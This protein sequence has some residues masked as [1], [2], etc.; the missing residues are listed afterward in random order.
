MSIT[1]T[2]NSHK[3][4][5]PTD[6]ETLQQMVLQ[7]LEDNTD[8][9]RQLA[10]F[11]R[12]IFG[13]KSE[14]F[15]PSQLQ[16]FEGILEQQDQSLPEQP[17]VQVETKK[18]KSN[19]RNGRRPLPADLPRETIEHHPGKEELTCS[20]CG[21]QKT[22]IGEEVTE[23]LDYIPASFVVRKHVRIKYACKTCQGQI[24]IADLPAFPIEKGRP[25][26]G[27]LAHVLTNKYCDHLPLNRQEDIFARHGIDIK[28]STMCDWVRESS[29]LLESIVNHL[30]KQILSSNKIHTD[31]TK[32]PV[33]IRGRPKTK[34][35]YLWVY[36][37]DNGNAVY[38]Y[39]PDRSRDGPVRF[40]KDFKGYL[41]ADAYSGY[42][43]VFERGDVTEVGCWAHARRK[44]FDS[45]ETDPQRA[46]HMLALIKRLYDIEK[47]ARDN[48]LD[49]SAIRALRQSESTVILKEIDNKLKQWSDQVLP[50]SPIGKAIGYARGQWEA[51]NRYVD[52]GILDIDNNAAE[53]ALKR[54]VIGRKN[55]L[56][57]GSDNGGK[58]AA[59]IYSLIQ[60]CKLNGVD[61]F[62]YLR[63]V[64]ERVNTHPASKIEELTPRNWKKKFSTSA[65]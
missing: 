38:D 25:G 46:G 36:Q 40:L 22:P 15:D 12:H 42:D 30:K 54:I 59:I 27:L 62:K 58:R 18:P 23:Q 47:N 61:S 43:R 26:Y 49:P 7:L 8:L 28:R 60:S 5:L 11:K 3:T 9:K 35:G 44:F 65:G 53:R 51:L 1:V 34:N 4:E 20:C 33:Q 48:K 16:L 17:Q 64:L 24:S 57:A 21:N 37:D 50:K 63:D 19:K 55:W 56:F 52:N 14:R 13:R 2:Y 41:Q 29:Y 31:D 6:I 32:V 10:Y 45:R 39:T